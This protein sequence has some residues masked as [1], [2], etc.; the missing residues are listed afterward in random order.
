MRFSLSSIS[1]D[2]NNKAIYYSQYDIRL[3]IKLPF[4]KLIAFKGIMYS[5]VH[6]RNVGD[7]IR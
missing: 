5:D 1:A 6:L 3:K 4:N 7:I 2:V